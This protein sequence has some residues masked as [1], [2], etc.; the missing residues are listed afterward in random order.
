[1][2]EKYFVSGGFAFI[3]PDSSA[4]ICA[5]EAV[6]VA[7]LD[8]DAVRAG[9]QVRVG[10]SRRRYRGWGGRGWR[11]SLLLGSWWKVA[12]RD[13][14]A[15]HGVAACLSAGNLVLMCSS[16]HM[17]TWCHSFFVSARAGVHLQA[18]LGAG[19]GR[20]V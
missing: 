14:A 18:G 7:D 9:L 20:R 13:A 1:V 15:A 16:A 2:V 17:F 8:A 19:Q 5:V 6:K 10:G 3:H 12:H 11:G 4:D